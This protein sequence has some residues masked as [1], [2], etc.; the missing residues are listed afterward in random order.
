MVIPQITLIMYTYVCVSSN[1]SIVGEIFGVYTS[2]FY[3]SSDIL[4]SFWPVRTSL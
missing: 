2:V 4:D 1:E 3:D